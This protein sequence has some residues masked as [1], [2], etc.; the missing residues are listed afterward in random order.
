MS[1]RYSRAGALSG[2]V[3]P[4][5]SAASEETSGLF[6]SEYTATAPSAEAVSMKLPMISLR[7]TDTATIFDAPEM[8]VGSVRAMA[9]QGLPS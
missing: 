4:A 9:R 3:R 2:S 8:F 7:N 6:S 1:V 5:V